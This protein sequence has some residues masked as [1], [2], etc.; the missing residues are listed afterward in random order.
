MVS[1]NAQR[2]PKLV[3]LLLRHWGTVLMCVITPKSGERYGVRAIL[4]SVKPEID[5]DRA[6]L[7]SL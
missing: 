6:I 4:L 2:A 3:V 7:Q 1:E 5:G